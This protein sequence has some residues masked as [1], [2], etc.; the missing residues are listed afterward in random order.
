M[1]SKYSVGDKVFTADTWNNGMGLV[2]PKG[3]IV[4]IRRIY[5]YDGVNMCDCIYD[6]DKDSVIYEEQWLGEKYK[7]SKIAGWIPCSEKLPDK[8]GSYLVTTYS[9]GIS[10]YISDIDQFIYNG[11]PDGY[12][13]NGEDVIAWKPLPEPYTENHKD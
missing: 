7:Q 3:S 2:I 1:D 6:T 5:K 10:Q 12:W 11:I 9:K 4:E 8:S 13:I